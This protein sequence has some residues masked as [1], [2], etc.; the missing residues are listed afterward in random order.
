MEGSGHSLLF[1]VYR[2]I[3]VAL[4]NLIQPRTLHDLDVNVGLTSLD[5]YEDWLD[6]VDHYR[7][8]LACIIVAAILAVCLLVGGIVYCCCCC[9]CSRP[10]CCCKPSTKREHEGCSCRTVISYFIFFFV[11]VAMFLGVFVMFLSSSLTKDAI[12]DKGLQSRVGTFVDEIQVFVNDTVKEASAFTQDTYD[13]LHSDIGELVDSLPDDI[14]T[15]IESATGATQLLDQQIV[16]LHDVIRVAN[17]TE[18]ATTS[19]QTIAQGLITEME[20][21]ESKF[22]N[23]FP[24]C[25]TIEECRNVLNKLTITADIES[26]NV[27]R[28]VIRSANEALNKTLRGKKELEEA[29]ESIF[30]EIN[31]TAASINDTLVEGYKEIM[32]LLHDVAADVEDVIA[33]GVNDSDVIHYAQMVEEDILMWYTCMSVL[34]CVLL[35]VIL[36]FLLGLFC[37]MGDRGITRGDSGVCQRSKGSIIISSTVCLLIIACLSVIVVSLLLF[38]LGGAF[39]TEACRY[40]ADPDRHQPSLDLIDELIQNNTDLEIAVFDSLEKCADGQSLYMALNLDSLH[41]IDL[42]AELDLEKYGVSD[43]LGDVRDMT[44]DLDSVTS[45]HSDGITA[46]EDADKVRD[47]FHKYVN[48]I[49]VNVTKKHLGDVINYLQ[50]YAKSGTVRDQVEFEE[51]MTRL[52]E[53]ESVEIPRIQQQRSVILEHVRQLEQL[54][55]DIKTQLESVDFSKADEEISTCIHDTVDKAYDIIN[56]TTVTVSNKVRYSLGHCGPIRNSVY[57]LLSY[58][59][60]DVLYPFNAFW[61]ALVWFLATAIISMFV[62]CRVVSSFQETVEYLSA[63]V[64]PRIHGA[65]YPREMNEQYYSP[66]S[67]SELNRMLYNGK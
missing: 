3:Q 51:C 41:Y 43:Y 37:G 66:P 67:D 25:V 56:N 64:M 10:Y 63:P 18:V 13:D 17:E 1:P 29:E 48:D 55:Q 34:T 2:T 47:D 31:K 61:F 9:C 12:E 39:H 15:A 36:L 20:D 52:T 5:V 8:F 44:I 6:L 27:F 58:G 50:E 62:A 26:L 53:M 46:L 7:G 16:Y 45:M 49:P 59:C 30:E 19:L 60:V 54:L 21:L 23:L 33:D 38:I 4:E 40:F 65:V 11:L 42:E 32:T 35:L 24:G 14:M 22:S 28:D 57:T